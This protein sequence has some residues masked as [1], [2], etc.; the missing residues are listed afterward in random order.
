[1]KK[2]PKKFDM[3]QWEMGSKVDDLS[4]EPV[5]EYLE[6]MEKFIE[7]LTESFAIGLEKK[8]DLAV[9]EGVSMALSFM[10]RDQ[11]YCGFYYTD[12]VGDDNPDGDVG[13][14]FY[15]GDDYQNVRSFS[16]FFESCDDANL[17]TLRKAVIVEQVK[18]KNKN[19]N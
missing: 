9:R 11:F 10:T 13:I 8:F 19:V 6:K 18:R 16:S 14:G 5:R 1:M 17:E 15:F 4:G 7:P 12:T 2:Q 3:S